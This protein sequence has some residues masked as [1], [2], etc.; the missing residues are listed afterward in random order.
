MVDLTLEIAVTV[1]KISA[2]HEIINEILVFFS[3]KGTLLTAALLMRATDR[4]Q[5]HSESLELLDKLKKYDS[6]RI[7]YYTDLANKW[8]IEH[9]L[10][11]WI[12]AVQTNRDT[13]IDLLQLN[14]VNLHYKQ[15]LCVAT[16]I[17][18]TG[19][20]L[21]AQRID[22]ISTLLNACN[23]KFTLDAPSDP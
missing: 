5:N 1:K 18:L 17:N 21:D 11:S 19:N 12:S 23:V 20:Q 4:Q 7:G 10:G 16:H 15:Y 13:P 14:L 2:F 22:E 6:N 8:S 9:C 3:R